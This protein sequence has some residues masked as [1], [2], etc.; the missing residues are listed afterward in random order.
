MVEVTED[1]SIL[2]ILVPAVQT[3]SYIQDAIQEE[4]A[5]SQNK[6]NQ[7]YDKIKVLDYILQRDVL[8]EFTEGSN[9]E[10][11]CK[12]TRTSINMLPFKHDY[13]TNQNFFKKIRDEYKPISFRSL[14]TKI[15]LNQPFESPEKKNEIEE[16]VRSINEKKTIR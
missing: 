13:F 12:Y 7:Y 1:S 16:L 14:S 15:L 5:A 2:Q 4:A 9:K 6:I 8:K 10:S 11:L 3:Q